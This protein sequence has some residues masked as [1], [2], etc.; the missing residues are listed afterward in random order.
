MECR[1]YRLQWCA[2]LDMKR[3]RESSLGR[4]D[5]GRS[6]TSKQSQPWS[7]YIHTSYCSCAFICSCACD[8]TTVLVCLC[9][10]SWTGSWVLLL[11]RLCVRVCCAIDHSS[12]FC[13][14]VFA[15]LTSLSWIDVWASLLNGSGWGF[16]PLELPSVPHV[17]FLYVNFNMVNS[18]CYANDGTFRSTWVSE[19]FYCFNPN[20]IEMVPC[21]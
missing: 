1:Y 15:F 18:R 17:L 19:V 4:L 2:W 13:C 12:F 8:R 5:G 21:R 14:F 10:C 9:Y 11:R 7:S 20:S 6:D 3:E 16:W